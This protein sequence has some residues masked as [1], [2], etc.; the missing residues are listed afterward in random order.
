MATTTKPRPRPRT[1]GEWKEAR[2][3]RY[4]NAGD[5]GGFRVLPRKVVDSDAFNDLTKSAKIVLILSLCQLDYWTNK[6][7]KGLPKKE[8][9]VGPLRNEGRFSL[10][11]NLLKEAGIKGEDTIARVRKELV[12]AGFWETIETGS[13][14]HTAI[15]QWS[16]NWLR[17]N[18]MSRHERKQLKLTGKQ[19]GYCHYP[20]IVKYNEKFKKIK[21]LSTLT[22]STDLEE[23]D[24]VYTEQ[25]ELFPD[26]LAR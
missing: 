16:D 23:D 11:N 25:L 12:A 6:K 4:R 14:F 3:Q 8:T 9:S 21:E 26:M 10:P 22:D 13:V 2:R 7:H 5:S 19:P 24:D 15:F 1:V 20:N 17:Y 18:Q